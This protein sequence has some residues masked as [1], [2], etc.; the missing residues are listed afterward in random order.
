[1]GQVGDGDDG[2]ADEFVPVPVIGEHTF[3]TLTAGRE[4]ACGIDI[5]GAA[6][7]WGRD[8]N[9]QVGDGDDETL[10]D[11]APMPV[12]GGHTFTNL[13]AGSYHTCGIDISG[14]AWCWGYDRYG[15]LGDGDDGQGDDFAPVPVIGEHTFTTLTAGEYHTCGIDTSGAAWCWGNDDLGQVGDGFDGWE[16]YHSP[17]PVAGQH[18]F[19]TLTAGDYHTCG[20]DTSGAA[21]C[22]GMGE[23]GQLG[24]N[25]DAPRYAPVPV[26]GG[27]TFTTLTAGGVF[28]C[29]ID[30]SGAAWCWGNDSV[31]ALGD[32]D[33]GR[34]FEWAPVAVVGR[35]I[36]AA[37]TAGQNQTCGL[38][39]SGAAWCWG[40]DEFGQLGDG[41]DGQADEYAPVQ[42]V[43]G[44]IF[45]TPQ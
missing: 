33:D 37:L 19:T 44:H 15:Q 28:T 31:G 27:H 30:S 14:A 32:G 21:W 40:R 10:N 39:I 12:A 42:V 16:G 22:W 26:A 43:G 17:V 29:G 23:S 20:I 45:A 41:D 3:T 18:T 6:W 13:T 25:S 9:G 8:F 35:H 34:I 38:E 7:C 36:F 24:N 11:F 4:H 1:V 2:Q 5:S